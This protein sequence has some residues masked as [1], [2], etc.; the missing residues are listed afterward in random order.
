MHFLVW[1][2]IGN[3]RSRKLNEL[4][5]LGC[6]AQT[7]LVFGVAREPFVIRRRRQSSKRQKGLSVIG[8]RRKETEFN[9]AGKLWRF[10]ER[11][12]T[13]L[14]VT[15]GGVTTPQREHDNTLGKLT[16]FR[17]SLAESLKTDVRANKFKISSRK[18][19]ARRVRLPEL[20][21][22]PVRTKMTLNNLFLELLAVT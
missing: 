10:R 15:G 22:A 11:N 20:N 9:N 12:W 1:Q 3:T 5:S 8:E 2:E 16:S 13:Y 18:Y 17:R 6:L 14:P 21:D 4:C 19:T 7:N